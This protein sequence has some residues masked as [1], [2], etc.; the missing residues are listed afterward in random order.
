MPTDNTGLTNPAKKLVKSVR[1][2]Y[3]APVAVVAPPPQPGVVSTTLP[4]SQQQATGSGY[5]VT[6][7]DGSIAY[8]GQVW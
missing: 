1:Y 6:R 8:I 3:V 7:A 2:D 4:L 5:W